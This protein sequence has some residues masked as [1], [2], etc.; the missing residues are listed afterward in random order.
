[1]RVPKA[2]LSRIAAVLLTAALLGPWLGMG[3]AASVQAQGANT[4]VIVNLPGALGETLAAQVETRLT[5]ALPGSTVRLRHAPLD[6]AESARRTGRLDGATLV[7]WA[8]P[9]APDEIVI[10]T[11]ATPRFAPVPLSV[12]LPLVWADQRQVRP[13]AAL[14]AGQTAVLRHDPV[15]GFPALNFVL[16]AAPEDWPGRAEAFYYR[17]Q[18]IASVA[19]SLPNFSAAL[20]ISPRWHYAHALAWDHF[21]L[22][23][24]D[25]AIAAMS[26]AISLAP[27]LPA[28]YLDRAYFYEQ[29]HAY[30]AALADYGRVLVLLPDDAETLRRRAGAFLANGDPEA[31]LADYDRLISLRPDD[32][33]ALLART[34]ARFAL[35]DYPG[36]LADVDAA[37]ALHPADPDRYIFARGLAHFYLGENTAAITDLAD[38]TDRQPGDAAGWINLGQAQEASGDLT[39]ATLAFEAAL[40]IDSEATYL[41]STLARL[42]YQTAATLQ[43]PERGPYLTL[44]IDAATQA[45]GV[46]ANDTGALLYRALAYMAQ[47]RNDLAL[48]DL[49]SALRS[50]PSFVT[51]TLNRAIVHTRLGDAT[52]DPGERQA[53]YR[54]ASEDYTTLLR[55][56]FNAYSYLLVYQAYMLV[57]LGEYRDALDHFGAYRELFPTAPYDQTWAIYEARAYLGVGSPEEAFNA[58]AAALEGPSA[59]YTCEA[60][61]RGG[62]LLGSALGN[63]SA[64]ADR[65]RAYLADACTANPLTRATV[66][67]YLLAWASADA[68]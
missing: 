13:L 62:L 50:D 40:T 49:D 18:G 12:T 55:A 53:H 24:R 46:Q 34:D 68:P 29:Q 45:L 9:D 27:E 10:T 5:E 16:R 47:G 67:A 8:A 38:Y 52:S 59:R 30:P 7:V 63:P 21:Y 2:T 51:A 65:L 44:A 25:Q 56:D 48:Y 31:A 43:P 42:Y 66:R 23:E 4:L 37:L 26:Q 32:P 58:Y 54:A 15:S 61:L 22:D 6:S 19:E 41:Y 1:M 36:V 33:A 3:A 11:V 35:G 57:E 64:G 17:G 14:I 60:T 39:G 28:L 20:D